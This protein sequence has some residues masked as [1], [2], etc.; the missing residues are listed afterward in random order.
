MCVCLCVCLCLP[1]FLHVQD[2]TQGQFFTGLNSDFFLLDQL[3]YQG[4]VC[5]IIYP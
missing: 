3:S 1:H 2:A 5:S 4:P